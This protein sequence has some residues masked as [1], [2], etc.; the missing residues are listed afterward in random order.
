MCIICKNKEVSCFACCDNCGIGLCENCDYK[1]TT[2]ETELYNKH[3]KN[4]DICK[5]K[6]E[7][8]CDFC[9]TNVINGI[10][11]N[12]LNI[13]P[14]DYLKLYPNHCCCKNNYICKKNINKIAKKELN[15]EDFELIE[16]RLNVIWCNKCYKLVAIK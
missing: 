6:Y 14:D 4:C 11:Y 12:K 10:K 2:I 16:I 8:F 15:I 7:G 13:S 1:L 5:T 3:L 9:K